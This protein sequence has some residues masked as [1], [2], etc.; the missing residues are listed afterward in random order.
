MLHDDIGP[1]IHKPSV[2][3]QKPPQHPIN[4]KCRKQSHLPFL[5]LRRCKPPWVIPLS[6]LRSGKR[7]SALINPRPTR[8]LLKDRVLASLQTTD[9]LLTHLEAQEGKFKSFV[10]KKKKLW[11]VLKAS[12]E[13]AKFLA[14]AAQAALQGTPFASAGAIFATT[15]YLIRSAK[16]VSDAYASIIELLE[17]LADFSDRLEEY[18]KDDIDAKLK[19]K[20]TLILAT[21]LEILA[22]SERAIA[23]RRVRE[24][25][26]VA[27]L[28]KDDEVADAL[29]RLQALV[30]AEGRFVAAK[31]LSTAQKLDKDVGRINSSLIGKT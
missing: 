27:F 8:D 12:M 19:K 6:S 24:F 4:R 17:G 7:P 13:P 23:R 3:L 21:L 26:R 14:D 25:P 28:G 22:K 5:R 1:Q 11:S 31:T 20:I 15:S 10:E 30:D 18:A 9:D 29:T 16:G 2:H